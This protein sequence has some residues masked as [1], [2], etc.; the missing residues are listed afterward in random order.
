[1]KAD[2]QNPHKPTRNEGLS[3]YTIQGY[4]RTLKAFFSWATVEGYLAQNCNG[5]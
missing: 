2:Q 5:Q 4:A 1:V 3:P